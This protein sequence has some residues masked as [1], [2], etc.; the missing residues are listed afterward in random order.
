[1]RRGTSDPRAVC[2]TELGASLRVRAQAPSAVAELLEGQ[3]LASQQQVVIYGT[4]EEQDVRTR[5]A[6]PP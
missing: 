1:M 3:P 2:L 4:E 6:P 5:R